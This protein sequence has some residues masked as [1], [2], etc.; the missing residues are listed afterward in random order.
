MDPFVEQ[1][2]T[3]T[4]VYLGFWTNW[5]YGRVRGATLTLTNRDGGF[6]TAF[7]AVFVVI[8]GRSFW[9]IACFMI[10]YALS[11]VAPKDGIYHQRQA[12]L[13]NAASGTSGLL[14]LLQMSWAW[15]KDI[16]A[17]PYW[18]IL[19]LI[20]FAFL[21][22]SGFSVAGIFSSRVSTSMGD[23]VLLSG[24]NCAFQLRDDI[25]M[26]D[27][28]TTMAPYFNQRLASSANYAQRCYRSNTISQDCSMFV[29][30]S[31]SRKITYDIA[32]PFPGHDR[33]C[34]RNS[35]NI[36][37]D[38]GYIDS[39]LDLG[40]N[41]PSEFRFLL[42]NVVECGPLKTDGYS[43]NVTIYPKRNDTSPNQSM[44]Y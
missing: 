11:S 22:L 40:I 18:R 2:I 25:D 32:C 21:T 3:N 28:Y 29:Q 31:L 8:A 10:H 14:S 36:R 33:I 5:S 6:L 41:T 17:Q 30:K 24:Q 7:L 13:R 26:T 44:Q 37:L 39:N 27:Y 38:T 19:P 23:E 20:V 12:I 34:R 9:R 1:S 43:K 4:D 42:R 15:R 16:R 35:T